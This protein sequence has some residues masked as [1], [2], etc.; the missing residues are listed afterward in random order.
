MAIDTGSFAGR[1]KQN[2]PSFF[3]G[4]SS[5][6]GNPLMN[7]TGQ[8][9]STI[10]HGGKIGQQTRKAQGADTKTGGGT[11]TPGN[12]TQTQNSPNGMAP[13]GPTPADNP[14]NAG[15]GGMVRMPNFFGG[16][17]PMGSGFNPPGGGGAVFRPQPSFGTGM[18]MP[19]ANSGL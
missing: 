17:M 10:M 12:Q 15:M 5:Q 19:Q 14:A 7:Q 1:L 18:G 2:L 9:A 13:Q 8:I 6:Y 16:G 3:Q 11:N 4:L